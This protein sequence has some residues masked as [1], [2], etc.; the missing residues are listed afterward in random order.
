MQ[1]AMLIELSK[2]SRELCLPHPPCCK[3]DQSYYEN[4][5]SSRGNFAC[6][7]PPTRTQMDTHTHTHARAHTHTWT[8][9]CPQYHPTLQKRTHAIEIRIG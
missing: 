7:T 3:D 4:C 5:Q 6:P 2:F 8:C 9:R 1:R